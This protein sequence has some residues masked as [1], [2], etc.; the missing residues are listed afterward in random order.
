MTGVASRGL[1][2]A[3]DRWSREGRFDQP[4]LRLASL[5]ASGQVTAKIAA[6]EPIHECLAAR[7][8]FVDPARECAPPIA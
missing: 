5:A 3:T 7:T 4:K 8:R 6:V 2:K 1:G